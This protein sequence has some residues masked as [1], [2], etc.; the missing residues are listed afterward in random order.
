VKTFGK[1]NK[2]NEAHATTYNRFVTS[3]KEEK[4]VVLVELGDVALELQMEEGRSWEM[5][6]MNYRWRRE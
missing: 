3:I 4:C 2:H 5:L 6:L 1:Q